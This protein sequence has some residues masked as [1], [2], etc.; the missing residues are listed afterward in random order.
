M[1]KRDIPHPS[2]TD[3][4]HAL[5]GAE[6][7]RDRLLTM[8][9]MGK[10]S[11]SERNYALKCRIKS[12]QS[13]TKKVSTKTAADYTAMTATDIVGLRI[14][15]I[16]SDE[17]LLAT[18]DFL[19][20][21]RFGQSEQIGLFAGPHLQD[22]ISEIIV[23]RSKNNSEPYELV[24]SV[25]RT[26]NVFRNVTDEPLID[27]AKATDDKPYSS[28]H[29]VCWCV[30]NHGGRITKIPLEVQIR[31][32]FE[33]AW[34]EVDH[35]LR[36]KGIRNEIE[37]MTTDKRRFA[38]SIISQLTTLK[39]SLENCGKQADEIRSLYRQMSVIFD[40][41]DGAMPTSPSVQFFDIHDN[42]NV[43]PNKSEIQE[44]YFDQVVEL[45]KKAEDELALND[46]ELDERALEFN[47]SVQ[48]FVAQF[49]ELEV[50]YRSQDPA[51]YAADEDFKYFKQMATVALHI[52]SSRINQHFSLGERGIFSQSAIDSALSI[53]LG[54]ERG[55]F[56]N[57][58][59]V[60]F[61]IR[62]CLERK[63][64]EFLEA[65]AGKAKE[66]T[67]LLR[68]DVRIKNNSILRSII[69]RLCGWHL[70]QLNQNIWEKWENW[71]SGDAE[72][73]YTDDRQKLLVEA[74]EVTLD[75]LQ[76]LDN[77]DCDQKELQN[78]RRRSL[79][80]LV[81]YIWELEDIVGNL[82]IDDIVSKTRVT[83]L[84]KEVAE[85][86]VPKS[87]QLSLLDSLMK[88]NVILDNGAEALSFADQIDLMLEKSENL[89]SDV[90]GE[91]RFVRY[92]ID[93]V[94]KRF[95]GGTYEITD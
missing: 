88:A 36:Y 81:C 57:D 67:D 7:I 48:N 71:G 38:E 90:Q 76:A 87:R 43:S 85:M 11:I 50:N 95:E 4:L 24:Y 60:R 28:I 42:F 83:D 39:S 93:R 1:K 40:G 44:T 2:E 20:L 59:F 58:S 82:E 9:S 54:M 26:L 69:P 25:L 65:A 53:L 30:S 23:Y 3:A 12:I 73:T 47:N 22:A 56:K 14:L 74:I 72:H 31:T 77:V 37:A 18:R 91:I 32:V 21:V 46:K 45:T 78:H 19:E 8:L 34:N 41:V 17:L 33:D 5:Y 68:D 64:P 13:L 52:L 55:D 75:S 49:D 94:R 29:I 79:N 84:V 80:N 15:T 35:P 92:A 16:H 10:N 66:A 63:S 86:E 62:Q 89:H 6:D 70:W 61:R 51:A 27:M